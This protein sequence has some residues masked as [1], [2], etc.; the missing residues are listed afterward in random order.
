MTYKESVTQAMT[1][2][3]EREDVV[4]LGEGLINAGRVYGTLEEVPVSKCIEMPI[5]EN[6]I[7]SCAIGLALAGYLP[8]VVFTRMDFMLCAADAIINH[9]GMMQEY[10]NGQACP[11]VILRAIVGDSKGKFDCGIQHTQDHTHMFSRYIATR[12]IFNPVRDYKQITTHTCAVLTVEKKE[13]YDNI[14][15]D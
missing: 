5:A 12:V 4:F 2:L 14:V 13:Y 15:A 1:T 3:G 10:S 8:V 11:K 7:V 9:L 6:L